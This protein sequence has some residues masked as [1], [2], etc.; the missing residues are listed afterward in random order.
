GARGV[1]DVCARVHDRQLA[2]TRL[3]RCR[4]QRRQLAQARTLYD[5]EHVLRV[6]PLDAVVV[7]DART[8]AID[9]RVS[10]FAEQRCPVVGPLLVE[11]IVP[12]LKRNCR[13]EDDDGSKTRSEE[14]T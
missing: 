11:M 13:R 14:N 12:A 7:P 5:E 9:E 2:G 4:T 8:E 6:P 1:F 3:G 10:A